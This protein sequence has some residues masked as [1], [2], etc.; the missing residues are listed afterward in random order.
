[1]DDTAAHPPAIPRRAA[2]TWAAVVLVLVLAGS[3]I[4]APPVAAQDPGASSTT[5][6]QSLTTTPPLDADNAPNYDD[7]PD[8]DMDRITGPSV[9]DGKVTSTTFWPL[10][11]AAV[12]ILVV[13]G[14]IFFR[15]ARGNK[16]SAK[17]TS[18]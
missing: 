1:M 9:E 13:F 7:G 17:P 15:A 11:F 6:D 2:A 8:L 14:T 10:G 18:G 16:R 12:A 3:V 5:I 4:G